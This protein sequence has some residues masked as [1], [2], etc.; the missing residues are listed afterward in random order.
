MIAL[1]QQAGVNSI[2][3]EITSS[4]DEKHQKYARYAHSA[5]SPK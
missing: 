1:M 4:P 2:E 5:V 3:Q